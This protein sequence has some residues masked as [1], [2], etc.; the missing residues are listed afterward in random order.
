MNK[1]ET[2]NQLVQ[3]LGNT[4]TVTGLQLDE[5]SNSC[6]LLFDDSIIVNIEYDDP[7]ERFVLS[8]YLEE[9]PA[10]NAEALLR[11]LLAANLYWHRTH[12]ATL[13]LEEG[14]NGIIL[15]YAQPLASLDNA[16]F[17]NILENIVPE[18]EKWK[19]RIARYKEEA[20]VMGDASDHTAPPFGGVTYA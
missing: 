10:E 1:R 13:C 2:A 6:V 14:T 12:G 9:L 15:V 18:A 11:E 4:L 3:N 19:F 5:T 8:V 16:I 20:S 7:M 17:E